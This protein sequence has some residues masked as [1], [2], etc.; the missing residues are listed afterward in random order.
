[1]KKTVYLNTAP[2]ANTREDGTKFFTVLVGVVDSL[3]KEKTGKTKAEVPALTLTMEVFPEKVETFTKAFNACKKKGYKLVLLA[4]DV[5][6]TEIK[7]NN[8]VNASGVLVNGL[9]AS[10][11]GTGETE[12]TI[13]NGKFSVSAEL[14]EMMG[15]LD[16]IEDI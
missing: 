12:L 9:Q 16:D 15:D 10:C 7:P 3:L 14:A 1:M 13:Q 8:Y 2:K 5:T 11:W 6:I 4:D